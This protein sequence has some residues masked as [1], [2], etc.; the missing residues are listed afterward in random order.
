MSAEIVREPPLHHCDRLFTLVDQGERPSVLCRRFAG[1]S[2][3]CEKVE[4]VCSGSSVHTHNPLQQA[5]RLLRRI[6]GLLLARGAY[7]RV[8]PYVGR[9][10]APRGFHGAHQRWCHVRDAI[11]P[12]EIERVARGMTRVPEH[13]VVLGR[14]SLQGACAVVVGPHNL[15]LKA[16]APEDFIEHHLQIMRFAWVD[17]QEK[18]SIFAQQTVCLLEP[19]TQEA[20]VIAEPIR[21]AG[22]ALPR[23]NA[24]SSASKADAIAPVVRDGLDAWT[25]LVTARVE[26]RIDID[27][28]CGGALEGAQQVEVF[29][30]QNA[31]QLH[32]AGF[33]MDSGLGYWV[34]H[35]EFSFEMV[36]HLSTRMPTHLHAGR[37]YTGSMGLLGRARTRVYGLRERLMPDSMYRNSAAK[38]FRFAMLSHPG[39]V[40]KGNEDT[41]AASLPA[42][43]FVVCDGMGGAAAGEVASRMAVDTFLEHLEPSPESRGTAAPRRA[44]PDVR[45][46][47][48]VRAANDTVYRHSRTASTLHGMGTTLVALL[49][50]QASEQPEPRT[51]RKSFPSPSLTLAHVGDSRCYR[52]RDGRLSQLTQDHSLVEEQVRAGEITASEAERHPMRNIITRAVGS[53]HTVQPE[54]QHLDALPGDLYLLASDGLTRELSDDT[55]GNVL[56]RARSLHALRNVKASLNLAG[57]CQTLIDEANDAGGGDNIT[58]LLLHLPDDSESA[59]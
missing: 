55:I 12:R 25:R 6:A 58:V 35:S 4:H 5:K 27:Q 32:L 40:R 26:G 11:G 57:V 50:E 46:D 42:G 47:E 44:T 33:G 2:A 56:N 38:P 39:R 41:C 20:R 59:P 10:L 34:S 29:A 9:R 3:A 24:V 16:V 19:R 28:V 43:A 37:D 17:M 52:L 48:A 22:H 23:F 7:D 14:P 49:V 18:A 53:Q 31:I 21:E 13:N 15:I 1:S 8:P 54:I 36:C 30:V 45:L 51:T